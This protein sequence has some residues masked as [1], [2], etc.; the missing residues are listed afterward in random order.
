[1]NARPSTDEQD[2][3]PYQKRPHD[4][5]ARSWAEKGIF[6]ATGEPA[7][8]RIEKTPYGFQ[9]HDAKN[10]DVRWLGKVNISGPPK[11][12]RDDPTQARTL[13]LYSEELTKFMETVVQ[14]AEQKIETPI[15][16]PIKANM[17]GETFVRAREYPQ[18]RWQGPNDEPVAPETFE[19][20]EAW[21]MVRATSYNV[22]GTQGISVRLLAI[23]R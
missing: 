6:N 4:A 19:N 1:M 2:I 17:F 23:Q 5:M 14:M 16:S 10:A 20:G 8:W 13:D 18:T 7:S 12:Y 15:A 9:L 11:R 22:K 3:A 21:V